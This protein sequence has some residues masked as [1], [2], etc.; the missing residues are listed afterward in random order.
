MVGFNSCTGLKIIGSVRDNC[1]DLAMLGILF[2]PDEKQLNL[3]IRLIICGLYS[4]AVLA[5]III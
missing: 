3:R 1:G 5:K 4:Y 2:D